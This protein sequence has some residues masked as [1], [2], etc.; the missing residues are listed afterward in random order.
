MARLFI[1]F[2]FIAFIFSQVNVE[3]Q[4]LRTKNT[5]L[6]NVKPIPAKTYVLNLDLPPIERQVLLFFVYSGWI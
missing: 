4:G 5:L 3:I 6:K 2:V 1:G